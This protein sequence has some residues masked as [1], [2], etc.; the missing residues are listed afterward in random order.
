VRLL[1]GHYALQAFDDTQEDP[2]DPDHLSFTLAA[3]PDIKLGADTEVVL[4]ATAGKQITAAGTDS[5]TATI[6]YAAADIFSAGAQWGMGSIYG[7]DRHY[8]VPTPGGQA[9]RHPAQ[10]RLPPPCWPPLTRLAFV[11]RGAIPS[12]PTYQVRDR[13]LA[14]VDE[15]FPTQ[16][17]KGADSSYGGSHA[18][19]AN[20]YPGSF[21]RL[22]KQDQPGRRTEFFT[23]SPE[24]TWLH[25]LL[26]HDTNWTAYESVEQ[27]RSYRP[28]LASRNAGG[29]RGD[30]SRRATRSPTRA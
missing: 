8:V 30:R 3:Q 18:Y 14:K 11:E 26:L 25:L 27:Y 1:K 21:T 23:A 28:G 24:I 19:V 17:P 6:Q 9:Q 4:D 2:N 16:G 13:D 7:K 22:Y 5:P 12:N 20:T 15:R 10:F 29:R